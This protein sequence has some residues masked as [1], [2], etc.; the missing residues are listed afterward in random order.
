M[1]VC[2]VAH[3]SDQVVFREQIER[4]SAFYANKERLSP[5]FLLVLLDD[6]LLLEDLDDLVFI[7]V[8]QVL[9]SVALLLAK[10]EF[11]SLG[12]L[13]CRCIELSAHKYSLVVQ[14]LFLF[15]CFHHLSPLLFSI[16]LG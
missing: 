11:G 16:L 1:L 8:L 9:L 3:D 7:E 4:L 2:F 6:S 5:Y 15:P 14:C 10:V 13:L 12:L